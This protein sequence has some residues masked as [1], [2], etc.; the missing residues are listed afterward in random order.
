MRRRYYR[1]YSV[2]YFITRLVLL[3]FGYIFLTI[4]FQHQ[5]LYRPQIVGSQLSTPYWLWALVAIAVEAL[6]VM[7]GILIYKE[8]RFSKAGIHE[9]DNMSGEHFEDRLCILF[10][11]LG[12]SVDHYSQSHR[13]NE[14][15]VDIIIEK[16]GTKTAV[17]AKRYKKKEHVDNTA[18]EKLVAAKALMN[19][20]HAMVVTN[21][22]YT[23]NARYVAEK[24]NV[25]LWDRNELVN[26]L[27]TAQSTKNLH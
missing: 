18:V 26:K 7:I 20:D 8:Y 27:I 11:S 3:A 17:Q 2:E 10:R 13:G 6:L 12:Y 19:C 23:D 21:S 15:G 22:T 4:Y 5:T 16:D 25:E 24:L 9:I 14:Y 1:K